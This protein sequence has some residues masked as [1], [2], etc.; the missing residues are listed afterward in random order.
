MYERL[1]RDAADEEDQL[2]RHL[3]IA[4]FGIAQY[5]PSHVRLS[6]PFNPIL[7]ETFEY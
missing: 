4:A 2:K 1:V 6:K 3:L 7:G 5:Q